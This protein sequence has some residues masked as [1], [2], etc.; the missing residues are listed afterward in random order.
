MKQT[1]LITGASSGI[2]YEL[3]KMF[4]RDGYDLV[5][6]ARDEVK[7]RKVDEELE[8]AFKVKILTIPL[9]LT[10]RDAAEKLHL[11]VKAQKVIVDVL[12]NNAGF[13]ESGE[14][15][16]TNTTNTS[17]MIAV[18]VMSLTELTRFFGADMAERK[19]GKIVNVA[20]VAAFF[21]GPLMAVYY[22]TKS[23]VLSF[24]ESIRE[25]LKPYGVSVTCLCP[26]PTTT[27]FQNR[28]HIA[29][30]KLFHFR[31]MSAE[32]VARIGY[33][34]LIEGKGLVVTGFQ[35]QIQVFFSRLI[36]HSWMTPFI[37]RLHE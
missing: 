5:L 2:G 33:R 31:T 30:S 13:G 21:P 18:N 34:G 9:D 7:L 25:E 36:P 4:A 19:K 10:R 32:S 8:K 22:A 17:N 35:N 27:N 26:G 15:I 24:S 29:Q 28:A 37:K 14:F 23:Y 3:A 12:I 16:K 1:V 20:S 6:V 11:M